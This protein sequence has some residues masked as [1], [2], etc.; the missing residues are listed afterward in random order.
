MAINRDLR[1]F[2]ELLNSKSVKYLVVGAYAVA[3]H[4][5]PRYTA[6]LDLFVGSDKANAALVLA[7]LDEFGFGD[8][9]RSCHP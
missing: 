8:V 3:F 6:D 5:R 9:G 1:E 2:V 7:V 4:A